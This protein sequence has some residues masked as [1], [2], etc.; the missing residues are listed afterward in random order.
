M[1]LLKIIG[2][3]TLVVSAMTG[4]SWAQYPEKAITIIVPWA[5]GGGT[6]AAARI[7]G[8]LL[9]KNLGQPVQVV[10]RTGGNGVVG[11]AAIATARP[12]GYTLGLITTEINMMHWMGL[13]DLTYEAY[14]P[15]A[16]INEDPAAVIVSA[17]AGWTTLEEMIEDIRANP[18]K[19]KGTG[20]GLGGSWHLALAGLLNKVEVPSD[21][22][23][24]I[25][26][27]GASTGLLDVVAGGADVAPVSLPEAASLL[28]AGKLKTLAIM[29]GERAKN[30][31]DI[32]TVE[33]T[34]GIAWSQ[35]VWRGM[36]TPKGVD[37]EILSTLEAALEKVYNDPE[38]VEFMES[39]GFGLRW[40][41]GP[42]FGAF[43]GESNSELGEVLKAIG[44]AK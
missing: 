22:M 10:N 4:A 31:P 32:P 36:V 34:M 18:G 29:S 38:Y 42:T 43:L 7:V 35:G 33:E 21:A 39:R 27:K 12:D 16:M 20:T 13:T 2:A 44:L 14:A 26:S 25:P 23:P 19:F 24:W 28:E 17:E 41:D 9:E 6:D 15:L 3:A 5:A 37:E 30:F 40:M 1:K 8:S 11:H